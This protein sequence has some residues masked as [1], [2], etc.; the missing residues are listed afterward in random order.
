MKL[1]KKIISVLAV[2]AVCIAILPVSGFA[3]PVV[4]TEGAFTYAVYNGYAVISDYDGS[5]TGELV[6]PEKLGGY[7]VG[8]ISRWK[9]QYDSKITSVVLPEGFLYLGELAFAG[10]E[11]LEKVTI[12]QSLCGV[13]RAVF[14]GTP[15]YNSLPQDG[16]IY[17]GNVLAAVDKNSTDKEIT[18]KEGTTGI[19]DY[20]FTGNAQLEKIILPE[21]CKYIGEY[22]F[23]GCLELKEINMPEAMM[24]IGQYAFGSCSS[25]ESFTVP[26]GLNAISNALFAGA[27]S[28]KEI[29]IPEGIKDIG[30]GAFTDCALT[31]V[32]I[33]DGTERI[34]SMAFMNCSELCEITVPASMKIIESSAFSGCNKLAKL[35]YG[36]TDEQYSSIV[37]GKNYNEKL[38][39]LKEQDAEIQNNTVYVPCSFETDTMNFPRGLSVADYSKALFEPFE[40]VAKPDNSFYTFEEKLSIIAAR[41]I[42]EKGLDSL[43][44]G[45]A[46]KNGTID[47]ADA[48]TAL[49]ASVGLE[50]ADFERIYLVDVDND[51]VISASDARM[52][53]RASVELEDAS[54]WK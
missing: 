16:D 35:N 44:I 7:P 13:G 30:D 10:C 37:L 21:S 27:S 29:S 2:I 6:I 32:V 33:P 39:A 1:T 17:I 53:L 23:Y 25:I 34:K 15:W 28:L 4:K 41:S 20:L 9:F 50:E 19:A 43:V 14:S 45:D 51:K 12:P 11:N 52:I 54:L 40:A 5:V 36:G 18:V 49:R 31:S 3:S 24:Y 47:A 48:R 8:G 22:A 46:D 42:V 38:V 26:K